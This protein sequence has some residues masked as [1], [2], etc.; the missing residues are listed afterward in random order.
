MPDNSLPGTIED[1]ATHLIPARD[2]LWPRAVRAV[3]TIP[4]AE[5]RFSNAA[6]RKAEVHTYLAWQEDPG[7]PLGLAVTKKYFQSDVG[8]ATRFITW[9]KTLKDLA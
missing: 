4:A 2:E 5:R 1:F 6:V 8:L 9:L 3:E 7:T